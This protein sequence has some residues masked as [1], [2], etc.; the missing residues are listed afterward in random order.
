MHVDLPLRAP[1]L[2]AMACA[3]VLA[4]SVGSE[5]GRR[6]DE[7]GTEVPHL[8]ALELDG[9][10]VTG[11]LGEAL[12]VACKHGG[13]AHRAVIT[14]VDPQ[15]YDA[16]GVIFVWPAEGRLFESRDDGFA[17][18]SCELPGGALATVEIR[19][20]TPTAP[21]AVPAA[22]AQAQK[23]WLAAYEDNG[24]RGVKARRAERAIAGATRLGIAVEA[25][26][27]GPSQF[28]EIFVLP[29]G[30]RTVVITLEWDGGLTVDARRAIDAFAAGFVV[31]G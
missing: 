6:D 29:A 31:R 3:L 22:V 5:A 21:D 7:A 24:L 10:R 25:K 19:D 20:E 11:K 9:T 17:F 14:R 8:H 18:L 4:W 15:R 26:F 30:S 1:W 16:H 12:Q 27:Q 13:E 28:A 23:E 2:G